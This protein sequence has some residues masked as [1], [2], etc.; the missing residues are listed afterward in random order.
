MILYF[1]LLQVY[2]SF[3]F[4]FP[5][6][7][8]F[9]QLTRDQTDKDP[10]DVDPEARGSILKE[11]MWVILT[12]AVLS[13]FHVVVIIMCNTFQESSLGVSTM[14]GTE[15]LNNMLQLG[16]ILLFAKMP[17]YVN[18][19]VTVRDGFIVSISIIL[20]IVNILQE[21]SDVIGIGFVILLMIYW[22]AEVMSPRISKKVAA[23]SPAK[24]LS[25]QEQRSEVRA[26]REARAEEAQQ[27][28][29][30]GAQG[31]HAR[32]DGPEHGPGQDPDAQE[33]PHQR[34][35]RRPADDRRREEGG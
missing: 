13:V 30:E 28:K 22:A 12:N 29:P 19:W 1:F 32:A 35:E 8:V 26:G 3:K 31:V 14:I 18:S 21:E 10:R 27:D 2:L 24:R 20:F 9:R 7:E 34:Q 6:V 17:I 5:M 16:V 33:K 23:D 11:S 15:T 4:V 25:L